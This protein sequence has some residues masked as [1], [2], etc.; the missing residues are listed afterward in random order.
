MVPPSATA[1]AVAAPKG[2]CEFMQP[3][4]VVVSAERAFPVVAFLLVKSMLKTPIF[5]LLR[6]AAKWH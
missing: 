2:K 1:M 3:P 4:A 5:P 6:R